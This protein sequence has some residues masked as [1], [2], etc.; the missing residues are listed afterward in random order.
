[1][2]LYLVA[3]DADSQYSGNLCTSRVKIIRC[4]VGAALPCTI[5]TTAF[6]LLTGSTTKMDTK[7]ALG[8][9]NDLLRFGPNFTPPGLALMA[10]DF[11]ICMVFPEDIPDDPNNPT[12]PNDIPPG[13]NNPSVIPG[14]DS[15]QFAYGESY[16]RIENVTRGIEPAHSTYIYFDGVKYYYN[17][18]L[19]CLL[20]DG[21]YSSDYS[22]VYKIQGG[23]LVETLTISTCP[24]CPYEMLPYIP[25]PF[26]PC[27]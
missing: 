1:M 23:V 26:V 18:G 19:T 2:T 13:G 12:D 7:W 27:G 3:L 8:V 20:P 4:L 14:V 10:A 22:I 11:T 9:I 6:N 25:D 21:Y 16:S 17:I 15:V 5:L 24:E